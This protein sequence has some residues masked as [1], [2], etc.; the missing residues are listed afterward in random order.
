[1][2]LKASVWILGSL[3]LSF[4]LFLFPVILIFVLC[5]SESSSTLSASPSVQVLFNLA[6]LLPLPLQNSLQACTTISSSLSVFEKPFEAGGVAQLVKCLPGMHAR[7]WVQSLVL[8]KAA[9]N[10]GGQKGELEVQGSHRLHGSTTQR[11]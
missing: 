7:S 6:I 8:H 9:L 4:D 2:F 11:I 10:L 1:M 3:N 5:V